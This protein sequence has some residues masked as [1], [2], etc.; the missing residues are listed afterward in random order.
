MGRNINEELLK[1]YIEWLGQ[2][3][4]KKWIN[5]KGDRRIK[6]WLKNNGYEEDYCL[7]EPFFVGIP[8]YTDK[9]KPL[10]MVVGQETDLFGDVKKIV[11]EK[12]NINIKNLKKS[13]DWTIKAVSL[14]NGSKEEKWND[15]DNNLQTVKLRSKPF[16][17]FLKELAKYY[18]VCWNNL[19]KIHYT[20]ILKKAMYSEDAKI[21]DEFNKETHKTV[22]LYYEDEKVIGDKYF[23]DK[24]LLQKE[25]EIIEPDYILFATGPNYK[26]SM[27]TQIG[28]IFDKTPN[29]NT[30]VVTAK[31]KQYFWTY[32]PQYLQ[33]KEW[34]EKVLKELQEKLKF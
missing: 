21:M 4:I 11:D 19:D 12:G 28:K 26:K 27:D 13:Q 1:L 18:N 7:S 25:I 8:E 5:D 31:D 22:T 6:E 16:F 24:S 34:C 17:N 10:I 33:R 30:A 3:E 15:Y 20:A 29:S 14:L 23:E 2:A 32:H 9:N